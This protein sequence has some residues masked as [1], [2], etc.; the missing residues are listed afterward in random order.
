MNIL[1]LDWISEINWQNKFCDQRITIISS[2]TQWTWFN[3]KLNDRIDN[4]NN[5]D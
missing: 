4:N 2:F 5:N 3:Y 1:I